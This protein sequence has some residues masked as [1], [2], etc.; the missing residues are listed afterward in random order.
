MKGRDDSAGMRR[1]GV[2]LGECEHDN[3][4][5]EG[6]LALTA[7]GKHCLR[8]HQLTSVKAERAI[9]AASLGG[10]SSSPDRLPV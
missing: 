5:A 10:R 1:G 4:A 2:V 8:L 9:L 6:V 3:V 7:E